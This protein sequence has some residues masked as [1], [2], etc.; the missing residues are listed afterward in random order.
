[1]SGRVPAVRQVQGVLGAS[2]RYPHLATVEDPQAPGHV[3]WEKHDKTD[4]GARSDIAWEPFEIE[5]QGN[6]EHTP[7]IKRL[8]VA[9]CPHDVA[10]GA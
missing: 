10:V 2:R 7:K 1:M 5:L 8:W 9:P 4:Y 3:A 6:H